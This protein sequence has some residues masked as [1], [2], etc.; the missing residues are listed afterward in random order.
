MTRLRRLCWLLLALVTMLPACGFIS[1]NATS[2]VK[3]H[4]FIIEPTSIDLGTV[5]L[6]RQDVSV[7]ITNTSDQ[8]RQIL[9]LAET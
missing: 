9:G 7:S 3:M 1:D 5:P 8:P 2:S 4:W 6:G